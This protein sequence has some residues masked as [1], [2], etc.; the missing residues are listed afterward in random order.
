MLVLIG[1]ALFLLIA[2]ALDSAMATRRVRVRDRMRRRC[3]CRAVD[4]AVGRRHRRGAEHARR[5]RPRVRHVRHVRDDHDLRG[6]AAPRLGLQRLPAPGRPRRA[7]AVRADARRCHRRHRHGCGQRL[8]RAVRRARD[9]V[10]GVLRPGR[11]L[12]P[13]DRQLGER[14]QVLRARRVLV[15][16][17]PLRH[18]LDLRRRRVDE[19]HRH[20]RHVEHH[21][22]GRPQRCPGPRRHR[23]DARRPRVQDRRRAR[24]TCGRPTC[25][26]VRRRRSPR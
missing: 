1:A 18:R 25:T 14:D 15:G 22:P 5:Q 23:A 20:G 7:G 26:R 9:I 12:S 19:H 13:Q 8:H 17:L 3:G 24:S 10:V 21:H 16:V 2:G 4:G 6:V 11:E